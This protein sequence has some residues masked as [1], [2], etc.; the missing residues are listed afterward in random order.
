MGLLANSPPVIDK[1]EKGVFNPADH[2]LEEPTAEDKRIRP[3]RF[4][5]V[6]GIAAASLLLLSGIFA[7]HHSVLLNRGRKGAHKHPRSGYTAR[8][9]RT[10]LYV[11]TVRHTVQ[12]R[13]VHRI[14][15]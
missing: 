2:D 3:A 15:P 4:R 7:N 14:G 6:L 1:K 11:L 13:A 10:F 8:I 5:R 9:E 12:L